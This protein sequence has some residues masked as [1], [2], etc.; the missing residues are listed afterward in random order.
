MLKYLVLSLPRCGSSALMRAAAICFGAG[1]FIREP[2]NVDEDIRYLPVPLRALTIEERLVVLA[3]VTGT[4]LGL[5]HIHSPFAALEMRE[6]TAR[7]IDTVLKLPGMKV[8]LLHRENVMAQ[9]CSMEIAMQTGDWWS[10]GPAALPASVAPIAGG[11][12]RQFTAAQIERRAAIL[13][14]SSLELR[15]ALSRRGVDFIE[16]S[17]E[18]LFDHDVDIAVENVRAA[19]GHFDTNR[20]AQLDVPRLRADLSKGRR[21]EAAAATREALLKA[22][23]LDQGTA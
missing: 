8:I 18:E 17:Y 13:D 11:S 9:I 15:D 21:F 12:G 19:L 14:Q 20:A 1:T 6:R 22:S 7:I 5:K 3:S 10:Y 16:R 23:G 4:T 2:F